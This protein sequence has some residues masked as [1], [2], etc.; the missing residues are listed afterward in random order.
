MTSADSQGTCDPQFDVKYSTAEEEAQCT[1]LCTKNG[2]KSMS[3]AYD[4]AVA[5][6]TLAANTLA[7]NT[8]F[9]ES[10]E[11]LCMLNSYKIH[12]ACQE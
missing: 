4:C 7:G 11:I 2:V 5:G 8:G 1:E 3:C 10:Q 6:Q 9:E 12:I